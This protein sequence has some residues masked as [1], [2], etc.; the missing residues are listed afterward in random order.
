MLDGFMALNIDRHRDASTNLFQHLVQGDLEPAENHRAFYN[1]YRA[2]MDVPA[3]YYL[4]SVR[5]VFQTFDLA[6][7]KMKY[8]GHRIEPAAITKTAMLTI[9]GAK[10]DISCPGQTYAAHALCSG[11]KASQKA[12]L[13]QA[14]V[15]HYGIFNGR[16]YRELIA[17]QIKNFIKQNV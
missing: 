8:H 15:G 11:L 5:K 3:E 13:L 10:D 17:P 9:E 7:G 2:V 12:S 4:E 6:R 14:D 1:E 16:R